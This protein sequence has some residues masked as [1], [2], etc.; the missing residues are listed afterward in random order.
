MRFTKM[1]GLGN[2]YIFIDCFAQPQVLERDVADLSRRISDRHFGVGGDGLILICPPSDVSKADV[3]MR[4]FN[5]DGSHAEMCGN[6]IRCLA[7]YVLDEGLSDVD[8]LR[9]ET[10]AGVRAIRCRRD[11]AGRVALASVDMG[12]PIL[13]PAR[14]PVDAAA[15]EE[16]APGRYTIE[17]AAGRHEA[18]FVSMGNPHLVAFLPTRADLAELDLATVGPDLEQHPAFPQRMNLH[19]A[20]VH[21]RSEA[22]MR[23]WERGSGITLACGTGAC[24][25]LVAGVLWRL[26]DRQATLHLPGGDLSIAWPSEEASVTMTGPA[27]RVCDGI[28]HE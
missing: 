13:A 25:V 7:K 5:A 23:T 1:H 26:L 8:P 14:I 10:G 27:C 4:M 12:Q 22:T 15:L 6:G 11:G 19:F 9:V 24:A 2:D 16:T 3:R 21:S 18:I 20:A 17:S 28:W